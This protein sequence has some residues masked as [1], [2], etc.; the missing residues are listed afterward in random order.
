MFSSLKFLFWEVLP[1]GGS[2][3]L[4]RLIVPQ[5]LT[6]SDIVSFNFLCSLVKKFHLGTSKRRNKCGQINCNKFGSRLI[7]SQT[8]FYTVSFSCLGSIV[9][10]WGVSSP[11]GSPKLVRIIVKQTTSYIMSFNFLHQA[12]QKGHCLGWRFGKLFDMGSKK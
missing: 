4:F 9:L 10:F 6:T 1:V 11:R 8:T 7:F 3:N 5:Y 2:P 12:V